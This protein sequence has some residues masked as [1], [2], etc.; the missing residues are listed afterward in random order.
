MIKG[1]A[2]RRQALKAFGAMSLGG[3]ATFAAN[4]GSFNAFAANTT[5]YKA[6]VCVFLA[7]G[8]D[9]H[10]T[11]IPFD[12]ASHAAFLD[13]RPSLTRANRQ[14]DAILPLSNSDIGGRSFALA[15]ELA[16]IHDLY[17]RG[18]AA[19]V[20]NVGTLIEPVTRTSLGKGGGGI[21]PPRLFSHNHQTNTWETFTH[22]ETGEGWGG[23]IADLMLEA[24]AN[25]ETTFTAISASGVS[26]FL[27]G[28]GVR[29]FTIGATGVRSIETTSRAHLGAPDLRDLFARHYR[30][31]GGESANL[32]ERD[33]VAN[34]RFSIDSNDRIV[35]ALEAA[36][37]LGVEFAND[38]LNDALRTV[39]SLIGENQRLGVRRQVF[40]IRAGGFDTHGAQG[41]RLGELHTSLSRALGG[42]YRMMELLGLA[43]R[44]TVFT[45][46]DFGR[47]LSSNGSGTDHGW[48]GHH[49][50]VGGA[51]RGGRIHGNL[52]EPL[53]DHEYAFDRGRLIP[54]LS[55]D[56]YAGRLAQWF[57][58]SASETIEAIPGLANFDQSA[59]SDL[60]R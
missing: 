23:R 18:H 25:P 40:Y 30:D 58:L 52:P 7:G 59:L 35:E 29:Q 27:S 53:I 26:S 14:R 57:G 47:T 51:V 15:P 1:P 46:S 55:I 41:Q 19:I 36:P 9:G 3:T 56:Q 60:F 39:A 50:V 22:K 32:F 10:D 20:G 54:Q 44:V 38:N 28:R 6:L 43:D 49:F 16:E 45:A 4:L 21:R 5:D 13:A 34:N 33:W 37:D 31:M 11:V 12:A 17:E 48:G 2:T 8:M 24:N 42:F